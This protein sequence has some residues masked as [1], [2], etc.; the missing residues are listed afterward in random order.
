MV[1]FSTYFSQVLTTS[2]K[3]LTLSTV[4]GAVDSTFKQSQGYEKKHM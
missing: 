4:L 3:R 1:C 2:I